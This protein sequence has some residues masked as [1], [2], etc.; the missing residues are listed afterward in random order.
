[1]YRTFCQRLTLPVLILLLTVA[2]AGAQTDTVDQRHHPLNTS[3]LKPGVKQYLVYFQLPHRPDMLSLSLWVR[4][5]EKTSQDN[6]PV[7]KITQHWYSEDTARYRVFHS[8]NSAADF[9]PLHHAET[10]GNEKQAYNWSLTGIEGDATPDNKAAAFK[11]A[12]DQPNYNWNLDI[13]TFEMLPLAA[14]K[15][16][17][18]RFYDAGLEPPAYVTYKVSGSDALQTLDNRTVDCWKLF[19]EGDSPRGRYTQ[20]FWISKAGHELLKEEDSFG[21]MYRYKVKLPGLATHLE[22]RFAAAK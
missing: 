10:R 15:T 16:F 11:L 17:V 1:M 18:I 5:I 21:G 6:K 8:V 3:L 19:T 2:R 14:G 20:T 7:F 4:E 12:F 22:S 9:S 13:E